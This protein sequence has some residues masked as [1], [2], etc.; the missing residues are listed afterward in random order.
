MELTG[1]ALFQQAE[2]ESRFKDTAKKNHMVN[3]NTGLAKETKIVNGY[4][5]PRK[6]I[7][8]AKSCFLSFCFT[9]G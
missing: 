1:G 4:L 8:K 9:L 3:G 2:P 7:G 6:H 5:D